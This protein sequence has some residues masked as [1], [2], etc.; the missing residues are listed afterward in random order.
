MLTKDTNTIKHVEPFEL[1]VCF[2]VAVL[3]LDVTPS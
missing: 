3:A 1:F 2:V